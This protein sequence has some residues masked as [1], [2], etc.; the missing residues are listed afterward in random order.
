MSSSK[1]DKDLIT[2]IIETDTFTYE[3]Q[4]IQNTPMDE[5]LP[6]GEGTVKYKSG[7][8]YKGNFK[9]GLKEGKGRKV[10]PDNSIYEGLYFNDM[11][12]GQGRY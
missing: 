9:F 6:H 5:F 8:F 10:N 3:G 11:P 2:K 7:G 4:V 12:H 1:R